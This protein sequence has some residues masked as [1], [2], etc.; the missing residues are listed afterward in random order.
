MAQAKKREQEIED[1]KI[2]VAN[3]HF[4]VNTRVPESS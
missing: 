1:S 3:K 4:V 2:I